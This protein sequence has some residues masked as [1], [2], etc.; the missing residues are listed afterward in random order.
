MDDGSKCNNTVKISTNCFNYE[1][2]L[3]LSSVLFKKYNLITR[4]Q[5]AG[6]D[7][8][9]VLYISTKSM[10]EFSNIVK[11]YMLPSMYYKLGN[12]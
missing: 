11:P 10:V 5:S 7:R 6:I 4:A 1:D 9:Y 8:G 2:I 12:Y 3:F